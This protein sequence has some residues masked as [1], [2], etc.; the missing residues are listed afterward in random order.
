MSRNTV[1]LDMDRTIT[2]RRS[3]IVIAG[4]LGFLAVQSM[5]RT[6]FLDGYLTA[7]DAVVKT[8]AE[9]VTS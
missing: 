2:F 3:T 6:A 8:G 7:V 4:F 1:N 5:R 9:A